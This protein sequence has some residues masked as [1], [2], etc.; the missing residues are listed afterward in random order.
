M[1][2]PPPPPSVCLASA[3]GAELLQYRVPLAPTGRPVPLAPRARVW[4]GTAAWLAFQ[5]SVE[6]SSAPPAQRPPFHDWE[7]DAVAVAG[8]G[9]AGARLAT[10][11]LESARG[12]VGTVT[13]ASATARPDAALRPLAAALGHAL[14]DAH[15]RHAALVA[16]P[17]AVSVRAGATPLATE[18]D[19][20]GAAGVLHVT[21][22]DLGLTCLAAA[23]GRGCAAAA[24]PPAALL[25][26]A[27]A[28]RARAAGAALTGL[29]PPPPATRHEAAYADHL[30]GSTTCDGVH[31]GLYVVGA[32]LCAAGGWRATEW[33]LLAAR[34]APALVPA[35]LAA[36]APA[37]PAHRSRRE[38]LGGPLRAASA[39]AAALFGS[40]VG[41]SPRAAAAL[42]SWC[43]LH[44]VRGR[45]LLAQH[46]L[47][48]AVAAACVAAAAARDAPAAGAGAAAAAVDAAL[49]LAL[50]G[51]ALPLLVGLV[52]DRRSFVRF[53]ASAHAAAARAKR[54]AAAADGW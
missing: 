27:L 14:A 23:R 16:R 11:P 32:A 26:R 49:R 51:G 29:W 15:S 33:P 5:A 45:V 24:A 42:A 19:L 54:E 44:R 48:T 25:P 43:M 40:P 41:A 13:A 21:P 3:D 20:C 4:S 10:A 28:A 34:A 8:P 50:V 18:C 46:A 31:A 37:S 39:A 17:G 7:E 2:P 6:L 38:A 52:V 1:T 9:G 12:V 47:A 36:L 35:L 22:S 53:R 30:A